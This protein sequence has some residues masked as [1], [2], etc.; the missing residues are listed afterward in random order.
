M[1]MPEQHPLHRRAGGSPK[2]ESGRAVLAEC[3]EREAGRVVIREQSRWR[4]F[5][6]AVLAEIKFS[7]S[8][9]FDGLEVGIW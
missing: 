4:R 2:R 8:Q 5:P 3:L 6:G 9:A 1:G 7:L